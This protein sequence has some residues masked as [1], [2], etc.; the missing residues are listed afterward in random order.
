MYTHEHRHTY[1]GD[2]EGEVGGMATLH[3]AGLETPDNP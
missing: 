2:R 3:V 1:I